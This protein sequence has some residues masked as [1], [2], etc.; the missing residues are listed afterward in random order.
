MLPCGVEVVPTKDCVANIPEKRGW[1]A[2]DKS[3]DQPGVLAFEYALQVRGAVSNEASD[4]E[5]YSVDRQWLIEGDLESPPQR[6]GKRKV[7]S[8]VV[9]WRFVEVPP[10]R[11]DGAAYLAVIYGVVWTPGVGDL[12]FD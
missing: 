9:Y 6:Q 4:V 5:H 12:A 2:F 10:S 7:E 11:K 8:V 1:R 3:F